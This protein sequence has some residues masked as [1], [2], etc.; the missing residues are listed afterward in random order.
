MIN[1]ELKALISKNQEALQ[2]IE[3]RVIK[4]QRKLMWHTVGGVLKVILI[5]GPIILGI[6]YVLPFVRDYFSTLEPL[7]NFFKLGGFNE[8]LLNGSDVSQAAATLDDEQIRAVVEEYC[9]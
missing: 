7:F 3:A 4:I 1:E 2:G 8:A 6:I 9:N 5:A